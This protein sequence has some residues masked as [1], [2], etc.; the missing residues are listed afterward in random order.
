MPH[1]FLNYNFPVFGMQEELR[2]KALSLE[3]SGS[4][5]YLKRMKPKTTQAKAIRKAGKSNHLRITASFTL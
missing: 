2:W 3:H 4:K 1:G 5:S